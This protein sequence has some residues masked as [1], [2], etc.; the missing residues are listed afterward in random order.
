MLFYATCVLVDQTFQ[1]IY[2]LD[3]N[4]LY[5]GIIA[6]LAPA[7]FCVAPVHATGYV[8]QA[9]V[10]IIDQATNVYKGFADEVSNS[11]ASRD[12]IRAK[13][14]L[15]AT[16]FANVA[17]HNFSTSLGDKYTQE[18][19]VLKQQAEALKGQ[20]DKAPGIFDTGDEA[21]VNKYLQDVDLAATKFDNQMNHVNDAVGESNSAKGNNYLWLVVVAG[22][23]S[24]GAFAWAF[25]LSKQKQLSQQLLQA[26][27]GIAFASLAPLAGALITYVS[28]MFADKLG[29]SYVIAYGP[30]LVGAFVLVQ[31]IANYAKLAKL[32]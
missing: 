6:V 16:A 29:G 24:A 31:A 14:A 12:S 28:Y 30:V 13:A 1:A 17:N 9:D 5:R 25:V 26:R 32:K 11:N 21:T 19:T 15:A 2:N 7:V 22:I 4:K 18:A 23:V 3:M 8:N 10:D 27:K 20:L